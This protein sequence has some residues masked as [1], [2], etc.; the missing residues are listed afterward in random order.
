MPV[1]QLA[2]RSRCSLAR[3]DLS[4]AVQLGEIL[5]VSRKNNA[6][7]GLTGY[8]IFAKPWFVQILEGDPARVG[9]AYDRIRGDERH[10]EVMMIS[11]REIRTRSFPEWSMAGS[12]LTPEKRAIAARHGTGGGIDPSRLT[13]PGIVALALELQDHERAL[14]TRRL[15]G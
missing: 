3:D 4:T 7:D 8:L 13:A 1:V 5:G 2:Y 15:A 11:R 10:A 6:R 14:A 9:E 12:I